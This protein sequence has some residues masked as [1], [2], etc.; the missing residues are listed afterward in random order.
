LTVASQAA[1]GAG[2]LGVPALILVLL[3]SDAG[4]PIP[5]PTDVLLVVLG[6]RA[7]AGAL[8]LWLAVLAVELVAVVSTAVLFIVCRG[9]G[10]GLVSRFGGLIGLTEDRLARANAVVERRGRLGLAIGRATPGLRTIT[11]VAAGGSGLRLRRALLPLAIGSTVFLQ[12]HLILGYVVGPEA[13]E[14]IAAL[15]RPFLIVVVVLA[16]AAAVAWF[17]GRRRGRADDGPALWHEGVCPVCLA[18]AAVERRREPQVDAVADSVAGSATP[19]G[20][21]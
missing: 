19:L 15:T 8:P 13:R 12:L 9:P 7:G 18:A 14:A 16:G 4:A 2:V 17:V 3:A 21:F 1:S 5:F 11:V 10:Y 6:E 20:D